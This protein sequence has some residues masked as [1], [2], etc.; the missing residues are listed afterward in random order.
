MILRPDFS[1]EE[2]AVCKIMGLLINSLVK[3]VAFV[4][5]GQLDA[6]LS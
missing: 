6:L 2:T 1:K 4:L 3:Q 5:K